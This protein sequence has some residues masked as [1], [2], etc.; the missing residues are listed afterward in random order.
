MAPHTNF[1]CTKCGVL[2]TIDNTYKTTK[3]FFISTC[4]KCTLEIKKESIKKDP[5]RYADYA[6]KSYAR[7]IDKRQKWSIEYRKSEEYKLKAKK[8]QEIFKLKHPNSDVERHAK[9][10]HS[11][12]NARLACSLRARIKIVLKGKYQSESSISLLGCNSH[13]LKTHLEIQFNDGM[14]WDNYGRYGWHIDHIRPCASFDL[15]DPEQQ[16]KC[17]HYTNLQPLWAEDNL[18]KSDKWEA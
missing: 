12:I 7:N 5:S 1:Y 18:R 15:T 11:N 16:K 9:Y 3:G 17:F 13:N 4:K 2:K 10:V 6:K 14:S 8:H